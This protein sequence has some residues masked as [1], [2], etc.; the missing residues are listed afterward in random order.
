MGML[1]GSVIAQC[2]HRSRCW[3]REGSA[4]RKISGMI[5][6]PAEL[7]CGEERSASSC[8]AVLIY[9]SGKSLAVIGRVGGVM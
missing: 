6:V 2:F 9:D 8:V 7:I 4:V 3:S 1:V 5:G